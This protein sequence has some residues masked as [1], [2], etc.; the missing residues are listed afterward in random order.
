MS[1]VSV[2]N[3]VNVWRPLLSHSK[4]EIYEFAHKYGVPYF[5]DTTPSWSTRGKLR[6]KLIPLLI[7][8]YGEG[9]LRNLSILAK[10]SDELSVMVH[11]TIYDP[12]LSS[13]ERYPSGISVNVLPFINQ[14]VSFWREMLK[15]I[16]HSMQMSLVR[17]KAVQNFVE[18]IQR[19]VVN[20]NKPNQ[21]AVQSEED[22]LKKIEYYSAINNEKKNKELKKDKQ[23]KLK[24]KKVPIGGIAEGWVELRKGFHSV[25]LPGNYNL[26]I[27]I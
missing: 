20:N 25:L 13:I 4:E 9:C 22:K 14:S 21:K 5:K 3:N 17:D 16:M 1:E 18:R 2:T 12:F 7:D 19:F 6:N 8:M 10:A 23:K 24:P 11:Q 15:E 27:F 26:Y